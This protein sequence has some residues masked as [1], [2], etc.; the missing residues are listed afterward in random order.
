MTTPET[1]FVVGLPF[2]RKVGV[3]EDEGTVLSLPDD[4]TLHNHI[5]TVHAGA[6]YS[7]GEGA[8]GVAVAQVMGE[9]G[10]VPVARSATID[11]KKPASGRVTAKGTLV[12]SVAD[13]RKRLEADGRVSFDVAVT[14]TA[15]G[16]DVAVMKVTWYVRR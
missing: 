16:V 6:L 3:Q 14:L 9:L 12:E 15:S 13:I 10:G 11:Y 1:S 8:S 5:G 2:M 4:A 7:L